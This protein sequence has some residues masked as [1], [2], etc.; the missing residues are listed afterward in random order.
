M[1]TVVVVTMGLGSTQTH[2]QQRRH[3]KEKSTQVGKDG[4]A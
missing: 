2:L 1:I 4:V 3:D